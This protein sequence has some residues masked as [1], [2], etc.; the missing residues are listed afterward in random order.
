PER[1]A[2]LLP[3]GIELDLR[4]TP[5]GPRAF[6]ATVALEAGAA[7]P[8]ILT[9]FRQVN[10]R[11]YVRH[12]AE[13]GVLFVRSWVSARAA[14]AVLSLAIP[15]EHA[16]VD[17]TIASQ[18]AAYHRYQVLAHSGDHRLSI[19]AEA[20][21]NPQYPGFSSRAEAVH[22]L[23]QRRSMDRGRHPH[24]RRGGAA[25]A[26]ADPARDAVR[27]EPAGADPGIG[28]RQWGVGCCP[29]GACGSRFWAAAA[30]WCSCTG[31]WDAA[32][33]GARP[34]SGWPRP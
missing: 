13:P 15:T 30:P 11:I 8:Y 24:R 10:Y 29:A 12:A 2:P 25:A 27:H 7:F 1:L 9:G 14:A 34:L 18:P 16:V 22:F 5:Q 3:A 17:I 23:G 32:R 26:G 33:S 6:L 20:D 4:D 31:C 28:T 21:P 19:D